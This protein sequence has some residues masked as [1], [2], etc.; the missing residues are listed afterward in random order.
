MTYCHPQNYYERKRDYDNLFQEKAPKINWFNNLING[1][2]HRFSIPE[3]P[4]AP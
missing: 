4:F 3:I 1:Q 2:F